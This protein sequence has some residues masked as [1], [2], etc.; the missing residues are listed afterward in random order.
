MFGRPQRRS[1]TGLALCAAL[2]C[3]LNVGSAIGKKPP[4]KPSGASLS[5]LLALHGPSREK[6]LLKGACKE[7]KLTW[8]TSFTD[9]QPVVAA[10]E[11]QYPCISVTTYQNTS[12]VP[13]KIAE[14]YAA[15]I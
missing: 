1:L 11:K 3:T 8:Y 15:G 6:I 13:T 14:E 2:V 7:K 4:P 10:F 5:A 9:Y 12:T